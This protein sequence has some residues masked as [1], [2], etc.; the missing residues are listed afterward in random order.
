MAVNV[1]STNQT[2]DNL[3]R[4]DILAW[5]NDSLQTNYSK[6]E[7]LCTGA[8]YC[9][10]MDILFPGRVQLK[11]VKFNTK[12]E[13]EYIQNYKLLQAV[14]QKES[15]DKVIPVDRLVKG[16]F[17]DNFE[18]VQWFKRFFDA[19]YQGNEYD[20]VAARDGQQVG[21]APAKPMMRA[22]PA[23]KKQP[24]PPRQPV[25]SATNTKN[26]SQLR[27]TQPRT[28]NSNHSVGSGDSGKVEEL[29]QQLNEMR[30]TVEGLEK[31]RDFYFGKLRDIEITCQEYESENLPA[32]KSVCDILYQTEE[33]K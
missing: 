23:A 6:I 32:L 15:V 21:G 28:V 26:A 27:Q 2:S 16:R 10:F 8:A 30:L 4:H 24:P 33:E 18:F 17:Q 3:S 5:L 31:E 29:K 11:K 14:F 22:S 13:H 25:R 12:L 19:N 9:Q 1:Y 7:E 20:A